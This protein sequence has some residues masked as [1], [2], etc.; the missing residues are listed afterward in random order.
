M[1]LSEVLLDVSLELFNQWVYN[2]QMRSTLSRAELQ[3]CI[4]CL[5]YSDPCSSFTEINA[6]YKINVDLSH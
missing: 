5:R 3:T 6:R 1:A 2:A 4:S